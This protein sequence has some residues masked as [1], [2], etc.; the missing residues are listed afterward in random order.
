MKV[1]QKSKAIDK[2]LSSIF[3]VK[4]SFE[5]LKRLASY[6]IGVTLNAIY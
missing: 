4:K 6:F 2:W 5:N 3:Q 1:W